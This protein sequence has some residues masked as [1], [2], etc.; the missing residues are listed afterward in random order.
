MFN[1]LVDIPTTARIKDGT[2]ID[3]KPSY[4]EVDV[5]YA[6]L[7]AT[8]DDI[9]FFG[10]TKFKTVMLIISPVNIELGTLVLIDGEY[11]QVSKVKIC[12]DFNKAIMGYRCYFV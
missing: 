9:N 5:F 12:R 4:T 1:D 8:A 10:S 2:Y 3:G 11:K 6:I 7:S